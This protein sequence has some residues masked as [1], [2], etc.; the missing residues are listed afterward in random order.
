[1][2]NEHTSELN[3]RERLSEDIV[4]EGT[5]HGVFCATLE[6]PPPFKQRASLFTQN[7]HVCGFFP[8]DQ[9]ALV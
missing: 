3:K 5:Q 7:K 9:F 2:L 8:V 6:H 4:S 1:M